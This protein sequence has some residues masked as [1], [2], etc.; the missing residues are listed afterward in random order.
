MEKVGG[1]LLG[2]GEGMK[3]AGQ[4]GKGSKGV[5]GRGWVESREMRCWL[6][7]GRCTG[8]TQFVTMECG[9]FEKGEGLNMI[10]YYLE[11]VNKRQRFLLKDNS[12]NL[13]IITAFARKS[14]IMLIL[15]LSDMI[16]VRNL[17]GWLTV[18]TKN[19][20]VKKFSYGQ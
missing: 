6:C 11:T 9:L 8:R 2:K 17:L 15:H 13:R 3:E 12:Y 18:R 14:K 16:L 7:Q 20:P 10:N 5:W 1:S 19:R 4:R